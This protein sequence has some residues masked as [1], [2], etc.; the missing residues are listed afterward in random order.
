MVN[1][2]IYHISGRVGIIYENLFGFM[3]TYQGPTRGGESTNF[4]KVGFVFLW[5]RFSGK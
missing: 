5:Q 4:S 2:D 1:Y 3:R